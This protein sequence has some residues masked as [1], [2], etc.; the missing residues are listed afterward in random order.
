MYKRN[1]VEEA[2]AL[3]FDPTSTG[4]KQE[5][6]SRIKRLLDADRGLVHNVRS[7]DPEVANFAFF[8]SKPPG[9]GI[10]VSFTAYEA[11]A[12]LLGLRL[13]EHGWPQGFAVTILRRL[14]DNLEAEHKR[15]LNQDPTMLFDQIELNKQAQPGA[16]AFDN[17]DPVLLVIASGQQRSGGRRDHEPE[18]RVCR[19]V[20]DLS[21][22][23]REIAASSWSSHELVT[24]AHVLAKHLDKVE[25]RRRGRPG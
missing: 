10:E 8:G 13:L 24:P 15:I 16:L 6:R 23:V 3:A 12:L 9:R 1:Q 19:G 21:R 14:R 20:T 4:P 22:F 25:P 17:T 5:L 11:F 2:I 7:K 18:C